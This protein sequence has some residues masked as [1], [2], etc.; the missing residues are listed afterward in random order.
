MRN[1]KIKYKTNYE[2]PFKEGVIKEIIINAIS[3]EESIKQFINSHND[4]EFIMILEC[5]EL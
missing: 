5:K 3:R 4:D 2:N 1:Y